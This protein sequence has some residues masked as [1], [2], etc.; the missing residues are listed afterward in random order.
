[1]TGTKGYVIVL[2]TEFEKNHVISVTSTKPLQKT[3]ISKCSC[4]I[5]LIHIVFIF[6]DKQSIFAFH[7]FFS[8]G[9]E[10]H[11]IS[12]ISVVTDDSLIDTVEVIVGTT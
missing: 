2:S 12:M 9:I 1:M 6:R 10:H 11:L 5:D 8:L 7:S 4:V 3:D